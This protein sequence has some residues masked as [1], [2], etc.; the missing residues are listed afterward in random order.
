MITQWLGAV[1]LQVQMMYVSFVEVIVN[2]GMEVLRVL[3]AGQGNLHDEMVYRVRL[4]HFS[5]LLIIM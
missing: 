5:N 4:E 3:Y 2:C 1:V